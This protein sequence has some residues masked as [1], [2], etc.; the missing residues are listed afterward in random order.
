MSIDANSKLFRDD[1]LFP[2][3]RHDP[4]TIPEEAWFEHF[5]RF[6]DLGI[7]GLAEDGHSV[8]ITKIDHFYANGY[9]YKYMHNLNQTLNSLQY[10]EGYKEYTGKRIFVRTPST[11]I[12]HQKYCGTWCGDTT[13][14]TSLPL[15]LNSAFPSFMNV[16]I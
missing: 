15:M 6:F 1:N 2:T 13:S 4:Y 11:F 14:D 16:K 10:F 5:K 3:L 9:S 7:I 8:E 12:G